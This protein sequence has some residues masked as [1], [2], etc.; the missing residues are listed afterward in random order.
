MCQ[1]IL[2]RF[3]A[4]FSKGEHDLCRRGHNRIL[5]CRFRFLF[6]DS[7]VKTKKRKAFVAKLKS[8]SSCFHPRTNILLTLGGTGPEMYSSGTAR[9]TLFWGTILA[10]G[11]HFSLGDAQTL[12][13]MARLR[14]SPVAPGVGGANGTYFKLK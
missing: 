8:S 14:N 13:R 11:A 7:G 5:W 1:T 3:G 9:V 10:W 12:I 6:I 4:H 2:P